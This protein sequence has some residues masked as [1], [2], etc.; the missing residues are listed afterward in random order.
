MIKKEGAHDK[1]NFNFHPAKF[2]QR[3]FQGKLQAELQS[4]PELPTSQRCFDS[5]VHPGV[6]FVSPRTSSLKY[7]RKKIFPL[8]TILHSCVISEIKHPQLCVRHKDGTQLEA[9]QGMV[10][11]S[12]KTWKFQEILW[13]TEGG[14]KWFVDYAAQNW[15]FSRQL[16]KFT[17]GLWQIALI[18]AR[19]LGKNENIVYAREIQ[20]Y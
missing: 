7:S 16:S 10:C 18:T 2:F 12:R 19:I 4:F 13:G 8:S 20:A 14:K 17:L 1:A 5:K 11:F 15:I 9:F 3:H 6:F